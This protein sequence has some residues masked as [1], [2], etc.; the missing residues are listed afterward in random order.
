MKNVSRPK[1]SAWL[2]LAP[3]PAAR[4]LLPVVAGILGGSFSALK[5]EGWLACWA[6]SLLLLLGALLHERV[7]GKE[8]LP[9]TLT[10]IGYVLFI[11]FSF[12]AYSDF[13][14]SYAPRE[15]LIRLAGREV[16]LYGRV[17]LRPDQSE[18]GTSW[19]MDVEEVR[20]DGRTERIADRAKVFMR[21]GGESSTPVRYGDMV[22]VKGKLDLIPEAANRGEFNP[23]LAARMRQVYVQLFTAGPWLV[24]HDGPSRLNLFERHLVVPVYDYIMK[25]LE[26]LIARVPERQLSAGVLTGQRAF[27]DEE[28]FDA[29]KITGTAHILAVSGLNVGL[30]VLLV[31]VFLQRLK[32]TT[33]GRWIALLIVLFFLILYSY[34]TGNSP[35][36]KR[37]AIM[38][39]V[40]AGSQTLGRRAFALNSLALSDLIILLF[41]PLDLLNPGFIMT[42]TAVL[43]ILLVYPL[44]TS[45]KKRRGGFFRASGRLLLDGVMITLAAIIG[46]SPVIALYFGTFSLISL[47]ANLPV[48]L[49][50][51][52]LMYALMPMLLVNLV[53]GYAASYFAAAASLFARLTLDSALLF[54][55]IPMASLPVRT[56]LTS[57]ACYYLT[58]G[59]A[60]F[61]ASRKAWW[62]LSISLLLAINMIFWH[63]AVL[64]PQ[65][66]PP[67]L[68]TVNLGRDIAAIFSAGTT[69][70]VV[71]AG[72]EQPDQERILRQLSLYGFAPPEAVISFYTP[73]AIVLGM[74]AAHHFLQA[75]TLLVLPSVVILRPQE[76]V[77]KLW[78]RRK[79]LLIAS[80]T[81]RL[82]ENETCRADM[83]MIWVWRFREKQH[84]ELQKWLNFARPEKCILIEG[85]FLSRADR[86]ELARF[87]GAHPEAELRTK[88]RQ[89][90]VE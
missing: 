1:R 20:V 63:S 66:V 36:V 26:E 44:F 25:S 82:Q 33:A 29:F 43:A 18:K 9:R 27:L 13:L 78:S 8:G 23:R 75:D 57:V 37:A 81:G 77:L 12:G 53:S 49:F 69:T 86:R 11:F 64:W 72:R 76:R 71:D 83:A 58:L 34:V 45:H 59:V 54:S 87:A 68:A 17:S 22:R 32:V 39:A 42:N 41:D 35:S 84:E 51:T 90:V 30:L 40:L 62:Q 6:L 52:I 19:I 15:G 24:L 3:W 5:I 88:T 60:I 21:K 48:V 16:M 85:S 14:C 80:G 50:S 2:S 56:D 31:H 89:V 38:A 7:L 28:L 55:K 74:P 73:D 79:S 47:L 4:L 65:K 10:V 70:V 67:A 46:V 61:F